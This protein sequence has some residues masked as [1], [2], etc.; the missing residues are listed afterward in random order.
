M[1][2]CLTNPKRPFGILHARTW[3][4]ERLVSKKV[5]WNGDDSLLATAQTDGRKEPRFFQNLFHSH[6]TVPSQEQVNHKKS[7]KSGFLT[8]LLQLIP[9]KKLQ[10]QVCAPSP[11]RIV[12][13]HFWHDKVFHGAQDGQSGVS[14]GWPKH[15]KYSGIQNVS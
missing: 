13:R 15:L 5:F 6:P 2:F 10:N 9:T 4:L 8:T 7:P 3:F 11:I 12:V 14:Q 1:C